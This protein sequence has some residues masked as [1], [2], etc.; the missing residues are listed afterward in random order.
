MKVKEL[1]AILQ[2]Y[3]PDLMVIKAGYEGGV[4]EI[5][6]H[7]EETIALNVNEDWYYGPHEVVDE[8]DR[9]EGYEHIQA[10]YLR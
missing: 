2:T 4:A 3:N 7:S 9:H 1:I 8:E 6:F 5:N 10:V